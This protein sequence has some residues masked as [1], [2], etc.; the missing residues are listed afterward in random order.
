MK[1]PIRVMFMFSHNACRSQKAESLLRSMD[2]QHFRP[3]NAGYHPTS[4][5]PMTTAVLEES[6]IDTAGLRAKDAIEYLGRQRINYVVIVCSQTEEE[7]PRSWPSVQYRLVWPFDDSASF[8][9]PSEE[10]MQLFRRVRDEI[11][12]KLREWIDE[13]RQEGRLP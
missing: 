4:I 5:D 3:F 13:P 1:A 8:D 9:G 12:S 6:G 10:R 7:C 2:D 11:E